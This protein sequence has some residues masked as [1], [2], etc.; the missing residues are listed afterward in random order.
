MEWPRRLPVIG[1]R[2][3]SAI[4]TTKIKGSINPHVIDYLVQVQPASETILAEGVT[5][6]R[7]PTRNN[8]ND[9]KNKKVQSTPKLS[10]ICNRLSI[11][12][13]IGAQPPSTF[14]LMSVTFR[15]VEREATVLNILFEPQVN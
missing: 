14:F 7:L 13:G 11:L 10:I 5:G 3:E 6:C 15:T 12:A 1:H 8:N 9:N 4:M 2:Q